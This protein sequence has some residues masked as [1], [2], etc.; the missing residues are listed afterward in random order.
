MVTLVGDFGE[1]LTLAES[2]FNLVDDLT[3]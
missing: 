2:A 3:G 1:R